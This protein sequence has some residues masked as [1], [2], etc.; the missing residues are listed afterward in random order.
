MTIKGWILTLLVAF[1]VS[2]LANTFIPIGVKHAGPTITS[3]VGMFEPITSV[4][5]GILILG[6][7]VTAR[8]IIA[9]ILILA[10]V[11]IVTIVKDKNN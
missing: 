7:P 4:I 3:I 1:F 10:G 6:E 11:L 8:N 9:C 5:L 2:F